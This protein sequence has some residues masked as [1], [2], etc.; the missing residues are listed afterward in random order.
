MEIPFFF[1]IPR[2]TAGSILQHRGGWRMGH[3]ITSRDYE[4]TKAPFI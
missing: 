3:A 4:R 2:A 1:V